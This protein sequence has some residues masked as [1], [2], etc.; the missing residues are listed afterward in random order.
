MQ[1]VEVVGFIAA[2]LT[3]IDFISHALR[4]FQHIR[5]KHE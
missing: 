2:V 5:H 1:I 4:H 3:I